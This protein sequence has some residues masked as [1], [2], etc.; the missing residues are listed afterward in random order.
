MHWFSAGLF[1]ARSPYY[2]SLVAAMLPEQSE[3]LMK[4]MSLSISD[5]MDKVLHGYG[6]GMTRER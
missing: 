2:I 6:L 3:R 5:D 4:K 1:V